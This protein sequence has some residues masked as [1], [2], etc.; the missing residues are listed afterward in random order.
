MSVVL[1]VLG[2]LTVL[3]GCFFAF[4]FTQ[5]IVTVPSNIAGRLGDMT[6]LASGGMIIA[7]LFT[8]AIGHAISAI[9]DIAHNSWHLRE[10]A[11]NSN[12]RVILDH[13]RA[14]RAFEG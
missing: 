8:V 2:W 14:T 9:A 3:L 11:E 13:D 5:A 6:L 7:G 12:R 4:N 1:Q 10:I